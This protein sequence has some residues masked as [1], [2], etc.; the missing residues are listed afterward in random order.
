MI[1]LSTF[2]VNQIYLRKAVKVKGP[3]QTTVPLYPPS[4]NNSQWLKVGYNNREKD[5]MSF[6]ISTATTEV[7]CKKS[8][9]MLIL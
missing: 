8:T 4:P 5:R 7:I 9:T 3:E 1:Q 6:V 2:G